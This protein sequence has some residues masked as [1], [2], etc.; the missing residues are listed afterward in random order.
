[1][2]VGVSAAVWVSARVAVAAWASSVVWVSVHAAAAVL[3]PSSS[4]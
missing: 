4:S 1:V 2:A 3:P